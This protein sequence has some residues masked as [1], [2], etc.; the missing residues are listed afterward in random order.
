MSVK[1]VLILKLLPWYPLITIIETSAANKGIIFIFIFC[2]CEARIRVS[3]RFAGF[4]LQ[5]YSIQLINVRQ[6]F[7]VIILYNIKFF[8]INPSSEKSQSKK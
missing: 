4:F 5:S 8:D 7:F 3:R 1:V 6:A 2:R